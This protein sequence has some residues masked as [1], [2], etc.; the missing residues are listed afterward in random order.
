MFWLN[1]ASWKAWLVLAVLAAAVVG[2]TYSGASFSVMTKET[3]DALVAKHQ[4]EYIKYIIM[5]TLYGVI[6]SLMTGVMPLLEGLINIVWW[7]WLSKDTIAKLLYK[8][9]Y[10]NI[11]QQKKIDNVDQRIEEEVSPVCSTLIEIPRAFLAS[12]GDVIVQASILYT[13]SPQIIIL[14]VGYTFFKFFVTYF[15]YRPT[16]RQIFKIKVAE[17]DLRYSLMQTKSNAEQIALLRGEKA[18]TSVI[19]RF[20]DRTINKTM[21]NVSYQWFVGLSSDF[22]ELLWSILPMVILVP[23]YFKGQMSYGQVMQGVASASMMLMSFSI[24]TRLIPQVIKI[25]PSIDR[26]AEVQESNEQNNSGKNHPIPCVRMTTGKHLKV[27]D[28]SIYV[29]GTKNILFDKLNFGLFPE[30]AGRKNIVI[31]GKTGSGKSSLFRVLSGLWNAGEGQVEMPPQDNVFFLPQKPYL[32]NGSLRDQF[33]YPYPNSTYSDEQLQ[34]VIQQV[35]LSEMISRYG[36]L[37]SIE[38]WRNS[39][40]LGEQQRIALARVMLAKPGYLFLDEATSALDPVT[41]DLIYQQLVS[42]NINIITIAHNK[43]VMKYHHYLLML[44]SRGEWSIDVIPSGSEIL[45]S[46]GAK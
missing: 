23:V 25:A 3:T 6:R 15:I 39:L 40:S 33:C 27:T 20:L 12:V 37:D 45:P 44:H 38:N 9:N 34:A 19:Y 46:G 21:I 1:K 30:A 26:L 10:Y 41:E 29:P 35:K 28:L 14:V 16:I 42:L 11:Q 32:I 36:S 8:K 43:T 5:L 31:M 2:Y 18:E 22:L 17:G 24:L 13:L 7:P 4:D